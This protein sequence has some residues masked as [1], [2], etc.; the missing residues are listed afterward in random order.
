[1]RLHKPYSVPRLNRRKNDDSSSKRMM[2]IV[3]IVF[4]LK[5]L[6]TFIVARRKV[7]ARPTMRPDG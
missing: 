5:T 1:M 6:T 2:R 4:T 7:Y 3:P